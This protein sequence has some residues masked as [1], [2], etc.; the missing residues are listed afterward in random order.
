[1]P[2]LKLKD[3]ALTV[4][5]DR[6]ETEITLDAWRAGARP[7]GGRFALVLPNDADVAE[8]AEALDRVDAVIL[9]FPVFKDGR[10][11][12]QARLLRARYGYRGEIRARGEV[13]R[14]Q[15]L[16][17]ARAGFD[18]FEAAETDAPG[19][20]EALSEFSVVYQSAADG[21]PPA[22]RRRAAARAA[23]A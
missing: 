9:H 5:A 3:G 11:Y 15:V 8:A 21:A 19:F 20:A 7:E 14:D 2:T 23:A 16:F 4:S 13:L 18:A 12:S 1:M 22:W 10:A 6:P 17:M